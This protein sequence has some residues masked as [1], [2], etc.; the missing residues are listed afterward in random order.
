MINPYLIM[1]VTSLTSGILVLL[2]AF[3]AAKL[4]MCETFYLKFGSKKLKI[5][6]WPPFSKNKKKDGLDDETSISNILMP[7]TSMTLAVVVVAAITFSG[8]EGITS[9]DHNDFSQKKLPSSDFL[10]HSTN[11][12]ATVNQ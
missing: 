4:G 3:F 2:M 1:I 10:S 9:L 8:G 11:N 12:I 6:A 7:P 5:E